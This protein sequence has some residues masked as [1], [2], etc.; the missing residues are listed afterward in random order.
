MN[1]FETNPDW[2]QLELR[3]ENAKNAIRAENLNLVKLAKVQLHA[4]TQAE[5]M[6]MSDALSEAVEVISAALVVYKH[7]TQEQSA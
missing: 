5:L 2:L 7:D 6:A 1:T 3:I 4:E